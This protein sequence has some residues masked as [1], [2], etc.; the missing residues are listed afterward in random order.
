SN[1]TSALVADGQGQAL[2][3][4]DDAGPAVS[5]SDVTTTE[6]NS[7]TK[8][9]TFIVSLWTSSTQTVS[10]PYA[11]ADGTASAGTDY[12]SA[13]GTLTFAP[14]ETLKA[15]NVVVN[16]DALGE[17]DETFFVNLGNPTNAVLLD[18]QGAGII[19]NDDTSLRIDDV[20]FSEGDAGTVD[21]VF[22][23]TLS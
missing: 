6:G 9:M 16:G 7:G 14:G 17:G 4:D 12:T 11:T 13:S 1:V 23:V 8:I 19:Q 15:V 3:V 18:G 5:I 22:T 20:T 10:V 21:A 2:I